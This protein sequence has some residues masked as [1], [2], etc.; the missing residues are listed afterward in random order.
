MEVVMIPDEH[1]LHKLFHELVSDTYGQIG[2]FDR[3]LATYVSRM[4]TNFCDSERLYPVL[5]ANG[6]PLKEVGEMLVASDPVHGTASSFD[7]ERE[8]RRHIGDY[9]L[10]LTGMYPESMHL[11]RSRQRES[12][13]EMVRAGKESYYVVSTFDLFEYANE[14]AMF[15]RLSKYFERCIYGLTLVRTE[16]ARRSPG[17]LPP[18]EEPK[19][20]M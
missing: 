9:T 19:Y 3:E 12:F 17:A 10:F 14:A 1:P 2:I 5:D 20:L 16:L 18:R 13:V 6:R 15:A 8:I 4:L 7:A 11:W